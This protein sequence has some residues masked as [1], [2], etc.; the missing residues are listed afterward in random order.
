MFRFSEGWVGGTGRALDLKFVSKPISALN[1]SRYVPS[2]RTIG[3]ALLLG[4]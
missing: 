1:Y 3:Y 2:T 4:S